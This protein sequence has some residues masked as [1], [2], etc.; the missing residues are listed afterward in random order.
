MRTI[1][2]FF[3]SK[4]VGLASIPE[5]Q[6]HPASFMIAFLSNGSFKGAVSPIQRI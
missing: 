4:V 5:V 1:L 6:V 2:V 3:F